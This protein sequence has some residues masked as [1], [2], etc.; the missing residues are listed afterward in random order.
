MRLTHS[1]D[2]SAFIK[3]ATDIYP[4]LKNKTSLELNNSA[5]MAKFTHGKEPF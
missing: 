1:P 2:W 4:D 3:N 5:L